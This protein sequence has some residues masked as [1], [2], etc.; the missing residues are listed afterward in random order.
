MAGFG[1]VVYNGEYFN[2][3][4]VNVL[5]YRSSAWLPNQGNPFQDVQA[6]LD[7][8]SSQIT[9][10]LLDTETSDYTLQTIEGV[11]YDDQFNIVTSSPILKTIGSPGANNNEH[12]V[13]AA[14]CAIID[15]R[16]GAQVQINGTGHSKRNR[17]YLAI[18]PL[19]EDSV[20]D[21]SHVGSG[22]MSGLETLAADLMTPITIVA[23]AVTLTP[24][25]VHQKWTTVLGHKVLDWR[26]YT[27]IQGWAV[28]RVASFRRSRIPE[29]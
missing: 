7:A 25:R 22:M 2:Q 17:G 10:H 27:D 8:V 4:V 3:Q 14:L 5:W 28:R 6:F 18:G 19:S 24:I 20:D 11:G 13:G 1:K 29:A 9:T 26:T 12:G 23:P 16:C 21:Y 15:L